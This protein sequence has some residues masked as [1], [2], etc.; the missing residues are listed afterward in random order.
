MSLL[1]QERL[2]DSPFV[3]TITRGRTLAAGST[4][5]PAESHWHMVFTRVNGETYTFVVGPL[6]SSGVVAWTPDA[7]ILWLKFKLG[8][9][10]PHLPVKQLMN[11]ETR[12]PQAGDHSFWFNG[13]AWELPDFENADTFVNRLARQEILLCDPL[14]HHVLQGG[15]PNVAERTVR[16]RFLRATG[17]PHRQISQIERALRAETLL[18]QGNSILDTVEQAGYFDQ[19]HLT[20]A[21]R[22]WVGHT[23]AELARAAHPG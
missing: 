20:R 1:H 14:V 2:S 17:L 4:I 19:P 11:R 10:L 23:P 12:L 9:F 15:A 5:R 18:R 22:Q 6:Q 7:E 8:T 3:E 13:A 16:H 21:L